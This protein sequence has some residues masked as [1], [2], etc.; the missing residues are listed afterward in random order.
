MTSIAKEH[1]GR[2]GPPRSKLLER[3]PNGKSANRRKR[4]RS[5]K[6]SQAPARRNR[7]ARIAREMCLVGETMRFVNVRERTGENDVMV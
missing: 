6:S 2:L 7:F 5:R 1:T 3:R 4:S